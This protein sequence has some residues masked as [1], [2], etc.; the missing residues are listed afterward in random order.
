MAGRAAGSSRERRR[1]KLP[2][3]ALAAFCLAADLW[4]KHLVFYPAVLEESRPEGLV[5]H[6]VASWWRIVIA[7]NEGVTF[8]MLDEAGAWVLALFTAAVIVLL[9]VMLWRADRRDRLRCLALSMI[10]GGAVGNLYDRAL[11]PL[12]EP[13]TRPGVRDFLD[14]Y[15]PD[16]TALAGWL[17][18]RGV[19]THWYTSNVADVL[20]VSG[21]ILLAWRILR[22]RPAAPEP[23]AAAA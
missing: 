2:W 13:D 11:R 9:G 22:E 18:A 4:T 1:R 3:F 6:R 10:I 12:V 7:Y 8:G 21:V 15:V 16:D 17:R 20:I 5:V 23:E 19:H 14:W